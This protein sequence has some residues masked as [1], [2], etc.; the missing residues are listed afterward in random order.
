MAK[1]VKAIPTELA[2]PMIMNIHYAHRMPC[3]MYSFGLFDDGD[4][5]G[6]CT[7]GMPPSNS[8]C[9]G[10]AGDTN[11]DKVIELN[12]LCFLP[13]KNGNNN[14]SMLVGRSLKLL[15]KGLFVVSYADM[16]QGHVGYVYQATNWIYT[17]LSALRTVV[18]TESGKH[19]RHATGDPS[20]RQ[21][22]SRKHRYIYLTGDK[23]K[24]LGELMYK[25]EP[26]PKG[27]SMRYQINQEIA[28]DVGSQIT[29]L[30]TLNA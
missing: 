12:R 25:P 26:Y 20:I 4:L 27:D 22:R 6:V 13:G 10:V 16:G 3:V 18:F 30:E 5:V 7:Y 19:S 29:M 1:S 14:A 28:N 23:K 8:L 9:R 17:G 24:Q 11:Q 21:D 15:P 2:K